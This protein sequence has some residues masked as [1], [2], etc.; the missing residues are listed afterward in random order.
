MMTVFSKGTSSS[1][2]TCRTFG[3]A[4]A[5]QRRSRSNIILPAVLALAGALAGTQAARADSSYVFAVSGNGITA[6]G[7]ITVAPTG[8]PNTEVITGISGYFSD[9]NASANFSGAITGL[10]PTVAPSGPPPFPAPAF[11]EA[12]FSYD[13][14][15]YSDGNSPLVC[16]PDFP[17]GPPGYPFSGGELDIYGVAFDIAGGYTADL[18]SNGVVPGVG[19]DYELSDS[20]GAVKLEPDNEGQAKSVS[21]ETSPV[22]E[23]GSLLLLGTGLPG[24]IAVLARKG[25]QRFMPNA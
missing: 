14:L 16:P 23:P 3:S 12:G 1:A 17:G 21:F 19:L 9:T 20:L 25:K 10:Q 2:L 11:T 5:T 22:P 8:T 18:W 15:F 7:T 13:N 6:T 24:L 4:S